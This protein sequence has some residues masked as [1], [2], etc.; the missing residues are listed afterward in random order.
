MNTPYKMTFFYKVLN[1]SEFEL[2]YVPPTFRKI[3]YSDGGFTELK[4][5]EIPKYFKTLY[6]TAYAYFPLYII[7]GI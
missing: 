3:D 2:F 7:E 1:D 4:M 6:A 5:S